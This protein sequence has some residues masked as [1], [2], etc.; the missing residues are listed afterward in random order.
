MGGMVR[1]HT[2]GRWRFPLWFSRNGLAFGRLGFICSIGMLL[3]DF[4][5]FSLTHYSKKDSNEIP[6][7]PYLY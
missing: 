6:D 3:K 5:V 2:N 7:C 4:L 1:H